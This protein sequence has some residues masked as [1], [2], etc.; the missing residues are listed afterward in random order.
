MTGDSYQII[1]Y[2]QPTEKKLSPNTINHSVRREKTF[3]DEENAVTMII[4]FTKLA[5]AAEV[6]HP[7]EVNGK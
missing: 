4:K 7:T 2:R 1:V 3:R 6:F 5:I